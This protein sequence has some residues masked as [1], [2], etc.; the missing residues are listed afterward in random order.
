MAAPMHLETD[1]LVIR[2]WQF[3]E[4]PRVLD[5][6]SRAEVVKWLDDGPL[7]LMTSLA[8]A[9]ERIASYHRRSAVPPRG[10]GAVEVRA[11]GVVAGSVALL[12]LPGPDDDG[13]EVGWNLHPDS[14]GNGYASEAARA[15]LQFGLAHGLPE[16]VALSN[17]DNGRSQ[18]V[19]RRIGMRDDGVTDQW[20][21]LPSRIFRAVA[22]V[23]T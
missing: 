20:Y 15:V 17:L 14:W 9:H 4:A 16:I 18:A 23:Y 11:T 12:D 5:I 8:E 19:C 7:R 21:P 22:G 13:V 2:P 6:M 10:Y 3:E 1:R